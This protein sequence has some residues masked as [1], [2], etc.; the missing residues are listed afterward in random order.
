MTVALRLDPST[1]LVRGVRAAVLTVPTVGAAAVGHAVADGCDRVFAV[2]VA[3][4][5]CWPAAVALLRAR[6][7]V[8]SLV[9]WVLGAQV[10]T[11]LVLAALCGDGGAQHLLSGVGPAMLAAHA[12][13]AVLTGALLS[14]AD[15]GLWAAHAL[16]HAVGRLRRRPRA[17]APVLV[18]AP[19]RRTPPLV[20]PRLAW[21][22]RARPDRRGPPVPAA[23]A[24]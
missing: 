21:V 19:F 11:H 3:A 20:S 12:T 10:A 9:A 13:A 1:G 7:G 18:R 14:R 22:V 24:S 15:A 5:V 8:P 2:L 23:L 4:G 16:L 6:R 17:A